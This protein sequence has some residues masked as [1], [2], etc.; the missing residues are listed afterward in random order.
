MNDKFWDL[1]KEK[2]DR[3][4]N[5]ALKIFSDLGYK[6]ASTDEIVRMAE[7]SKGLLFHYF[8]SKQGLYFFIYEY[9]VRYMQMEYARALDP[10]ETDFFVIQ[11]QLE[12]AK[13]AVMKNYPYMNHFLNKAFLE[14]D[15]TV[16]ND[17]SD[18]MD[19]YSANL[20]KIYST[21]DLSLFQED[22]NPS[23]VL[24]VVLFTVDGLR[25]EQCQAGRLD[26]DALYE[27][28]LGILDMMKKHFYK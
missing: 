22:I 5:A 25:N 16:L 19:E 28:T 14:D 9:S 8:E 18:L 6:R 11:K 15:P 26:P 21:A 23:E 24:K 4:I 1:K 17:V 12:Q 13:R 2:Q 7:I 20:Q 10:A 27:E 3:M